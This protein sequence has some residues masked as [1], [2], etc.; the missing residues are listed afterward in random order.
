MEGISVELD[1]QGRK[2]NEKNTWIKRNYTI[3]TVN[4]NDRF[5]LTPKIYLTL[6]SLKSINYVWPNTSG[7]NA[8]PVTVSNRRRT[9]ISNRGVLSCQ[10]RGN[11]KDYTNVEVYC[12]ILRN[13]ILNNTKPNVNTDKE[14][15][16]ERIAIFTTL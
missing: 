16:E 9:L 4:L 13:A 12:L 1:F 2:R 5:C 3:L 6:N 14:H 11:K 8:L 15:V 10:C 7:K